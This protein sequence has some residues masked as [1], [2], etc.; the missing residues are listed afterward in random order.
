MGLV[1]SRLL[2]KNSHLM[3][4]FSVTDEWDDEPASVRVAFVR[5]VQSDMVLIARNSGIDRQNQVRIRLLHR[6]AIYDCR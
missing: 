6:V 2:L 3:I 1:G 5:S 4:T